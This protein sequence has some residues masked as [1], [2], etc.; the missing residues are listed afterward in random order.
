MSRAVERVDA[1]L[2]AH[3]DRHHPLSRPWLRALIVRCVAGEMDYHPVQ[4][5][6]AYYAWKRRTEYL[7]R[8]DALTDWLEAAEMLNDC[9]EA[10]EL[11]V[12]PW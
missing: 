2:S 5:L 6:A 4:Q 11:P 8:G 9:A 1:P 3:P 10:C 7:D 12:L